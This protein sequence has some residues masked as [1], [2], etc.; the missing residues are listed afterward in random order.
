MPSPSRKITFFGCLF[1]SAE[2][3]ARSVSV[4]WENAPVAAA[5]PAA[6][7]DSAKTVAS[8]TERRLPFV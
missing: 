8:A 4:W 1:L 7:A 2:E 3:T 5:V 6:I